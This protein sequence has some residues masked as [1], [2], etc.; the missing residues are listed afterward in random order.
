MV[1]IKHFELAKK[2]NLPMF[3]HSRS[4]EKDFYD[5]LKANIE[6]IPGGILHCFTGSVEEMK[7]LLELGIYIGLAGL[8]FKTEE[9]LKMVKQ[10]PLEKIVLGTDCPFCIV[11]DDYAGAKYIKTHFE[12]TP[13]S[14]Y[15][16]D[17]LVKGRT[18]PCS[19]V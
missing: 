10:I 14:M 18:E 19:L 13:K 17:N 9:N 1:F 16:T 7:N 12:I 4:S 15:K 6:G 11:K 5:I 3:F 2:F 8:S